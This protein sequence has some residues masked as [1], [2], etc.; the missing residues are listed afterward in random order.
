MFISHSYETFKV[1]TNE[2]I[3]KVGTLPSMLVI[4]NSKRNVDVISFV[5]PDNVVKV[6]QLVI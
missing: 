3:P 6:Q 1:I 4:D 5:T 2:F